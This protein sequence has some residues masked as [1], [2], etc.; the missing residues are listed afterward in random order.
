MTRK[1]LN[2]A[3][4][5]IFVSNCITM[6]RAATK[7]PITENYLGSNVV[8]AGNPKLPSFTLTNEQ[9]TS[10]PPIHPDIYQDSLLSAVSVANVHFL[11][12]FTCIYPIK[13]I[14]H[15]LCSHFYRTNVVMAQRSIELSHQMDTYWKFIAL[16]RHHVMC[17]QKG[18]RSFFFSTVFSI[19]RLLG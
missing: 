13:C 7:P 19:H 10:L 15:I 8:P 1:I 12:V 9:I 11:F 17:L 18:S 6:M 14:Y 4:L 2:C 16:Y 3:A 5:I